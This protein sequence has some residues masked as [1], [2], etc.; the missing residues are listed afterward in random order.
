MRQ[1]ISNS[2]LILRSSALDTAVSKDS[3]VTPFPRFYA[4]WI[5]DRPVGRYLFS[6][7]GLWPT[8]STYEYIS[9]EKCPGTREYAI[10]R[11]ND[12]DSFPRSE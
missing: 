2:R 3:D 6:T 4:Q 9:F 5:V 1:G 8:S 7:R 12:L 10:K 11:E